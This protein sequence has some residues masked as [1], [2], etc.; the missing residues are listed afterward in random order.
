[1]SEPLE[2]DGYIHQD[3]FPARLRQAIDAFGS[4][5]ALAQSI[6]RSDGA[7]RKWLRGASEPNVTDLRA[8][9]AATG[10]RAQWLITGQ[11]E[12]GIIP[13]GVRQAPPLY[14]VGSPVEVD[15]ALLERIMDTLEEELAASGIEVKKAKRSGMVV[16][17]YALFRHN[18][19][20]DRDAINRLVKLAA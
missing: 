14:R 15:N 10:A 17:L 16:T 4:V 6:E 20:I 2:N 1:M 12:S 5:T 3:E 8:I 11:G 9:C 19:V 7:V 13:K 18:N